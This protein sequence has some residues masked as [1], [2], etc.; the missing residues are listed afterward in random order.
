MDKI[1]VARR[2]LGTALYLFL[3]GMD[4]VSVHC[5]ACGGGEIAGWLAHRTTGEN[6]EAHALATIPE[7][8]AGK[9][10]ELRNQLWNAFKHASTR[11]GKDRQ[12]EALFAEF[13]PDHNEH[14]LFIGWLDYG[15][16]ALPMPVEAQVFQIWYLAKYPAKLDPASNYAP[17]RHYFPQLAKLPQDRQRARLI[18]ECSKAR[19]NNALMRSPA[20]D[21]RPLL[22]P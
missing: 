12:D 8:E 6:F 3:R 14:F 18:E 10:R 2:Q 1:E 20:T 21:P 16:A 17:M 5:L 7:L 13:Q 15:A 9:I 19:D 4:P 11:D 22:L